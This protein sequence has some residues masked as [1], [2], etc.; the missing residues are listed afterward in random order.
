MAVKPFFRSIEIR[1][2]PS[3]QPSV[4][5]PLTILASISGH[6][7][8]LHFHAYSSF[9]PENDGFHGRKPLNFIDFCLFYEILALFCTF[10]HFLAPFH[11]TTLKLFTIVY[12]FSIR[13]FLVLSTLFSLIHLSLFLVIFSIFFIYSIHLSSAI[14]YFMDEISSLLHFFTI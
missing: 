5:P 8:R 13:L 6:F 12:P 9:R 11:P 10:L 14:L 1:P 7:L 3:P 4:R 2:S